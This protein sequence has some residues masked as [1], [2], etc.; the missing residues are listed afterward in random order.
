MLDIN[1]I[2]ANKDKV[3]E[4]IK[5]KDLKLDLEELLKISGERGKLLNEIDALRAKQND[6]NKKILKLS[7]EE[8]TEALAEMKKVADEVKTKQDT[9]K[10]I[11]VKFD[12]LMYLVPNIPSADSP[13]GGEDANKVM[14]TWGEPTKFD[15]NPKSHIELAKELDLVDFER[16]VKTSG[17][18][19][20]YLKNEAAV[21]HLAVLFYAYQ[22]MIKEGFVPMITPT[23][24]KSFALF[25]SGHF[26]FGKEDIYELANTGKDETGGQIAEPLYL[27]GTSEPALLAYRS[28]EVLEESELPVKYCGFSQCY[29]NE[30]GSYGKDTK[31]LYRIHE[32]MKVE[33]VVICEAD[34]KI[35]GEWLQK[36]RGFAQEILKDLKLPHRVVQIA[37]GDMGAGKRKM[38]DIETYMPSREGYGETH[39]DSDLTDWQTRRLNIKY[40]TKDGQKKFAYAL[41]NTVVASPRILIAILENFQEKDGSIKIPEVLVP[42]CGFE[43]ITKH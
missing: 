41:N 36:M 16:G 43:E 1:F 31:G 11:E 22:K 18:R 24:L 38:Y 30:V 4:A 15:F 21:L 20:Y 5:A 9:L 39:S 14:E 23:I 25:G 6:F 40:K 19:G 27:A 37:T 42:Y 28:G 2:K 10:N 26:P 32:F 29:R 3:A 8:K 17:F 13:V 35:S 12:A 33:Q 34:E 7:G